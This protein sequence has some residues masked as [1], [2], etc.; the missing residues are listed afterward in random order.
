MIH[1]W[2]AVLIKMRNLDTDR[3]AKRDDCV[4]RDRRSPRDGEGQDWGDESLSCGMPKTLNNHRRLGEAWNRFFLSASRGTTPANIL[5]LD[6]Q[7]PELR[8]I[9]VKP[10]NWFHFVIAD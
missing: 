6:F 8:E 2:T 10:P 4:K 5:I 3:H 1:C 7:P 9:S